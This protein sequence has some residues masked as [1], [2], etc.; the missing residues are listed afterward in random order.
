MGF[1]K[2]IN[3]PAEGVIIRLKK[4]I[5]NDPRKKLLSRVVCRYTYVRYKYRGSRLS[6]VGD[7]NHF[8]FC[9]HCCS[10]FDGGFGE[11]F[12]AKPGKLLISGPSPVISAV[13]TKNERFYLHW[14]K[15][16]SL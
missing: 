2:I 13:P 9:F 5:S 12:W 6:S 14:L 4:Y 7:E 8:N 15:A 11:L 10:S 16:M 1:S 3:N